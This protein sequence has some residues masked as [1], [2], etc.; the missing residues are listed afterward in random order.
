MGSSC[1]IVGADFEDQ[2]EG[3]QVQFLGCR[4]VAWHR[5]ALQGS[6]CQQHSPCMPGADIP[7]APSYAPHTPHPTP[8]PPAPPVLQ[9]CGCPG[10]PC[11]AQAGCGALP[12]LLLCAKPGTAPCCCCACP[13]HVS[14]CL[15]P[16][17]QP[18]PHPTCLSLCAQPLP[19]PTCLAPCPLPH[20]TC[21]ALCVQPLPHPTCL[22]PLP[23]AARGALPS[24]AA[25]T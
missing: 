17:A 14:S 8:H 19:H 6:S 7:A 2:N 21:L 9:G 1:R 10:L 18:L 16:C 15:A 4:V 13:R 24:A 20:P 23:R 3:C 11:H 22:A 12:A 25:G 5:T